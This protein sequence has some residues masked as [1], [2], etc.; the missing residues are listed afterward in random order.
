MEKVMYIAEYRMGNWDDYRWQFS[1]FADSPQTIKDY[2]ALF[3]HTP[4]VWY[5]RHRA[6][7][8]RRKI[9]GKTETYRITQVSAVTGEDVTKVLERR[10]ARQLAEAK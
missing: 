7:Y 1:M 9:F 3:N 2:L 8:A 6:E 5:S 4:L 10:K